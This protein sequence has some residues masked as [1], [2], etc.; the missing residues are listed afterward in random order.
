MLAV[1][2]A[3]LS[4]CKIFGAPKRRKISKTHKAKEVLSE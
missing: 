2:S 3:P 1:N 4:L